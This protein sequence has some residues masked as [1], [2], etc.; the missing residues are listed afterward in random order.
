MEIILFLFF[1]FIG[2][3]FLK[4]Y[5]YMYLAFSFYDFCGL[6]ALYINFLIHVPVSINIVT[7]FKTNHELLIFDSPSGQTVVMAC[8]SIWI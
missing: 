1:L 4:L 2:F 3:Y 7:Y 6:C 5:F 8:S